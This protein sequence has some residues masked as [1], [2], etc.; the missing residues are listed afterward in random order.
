MLVIYEPGVLYRDF[1]PALRLLRTRIRVARGALCSAGLA[2]RAGRLTCRLAHG[3]GFIHRIT[4]YQSRS[5][6]FLWSLGSSYLVEISSGSIA[7]QNLSQIVLS[8]RIYR[9]RKLDL[10]QLAQL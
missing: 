10:T 9:L 2:E 3:A 6:A 5:A 1:T 8:Q 7:D 4:V